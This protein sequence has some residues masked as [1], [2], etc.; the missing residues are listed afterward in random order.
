[1]AACTLAGIVL[2]PAGAVVGGS[3]PAAVASLPAL[4]AAGAA[5]GAA[6]AVALTCGRRHAVRVTGRVHRRAGPAL[7]AAAREAAVSATRW[8]VAAALAVGVLVSAA[9]GGGAASDAGG[10]GGGG[11]GVDAAT[12]TGVWL[13]LALAFFIASAARV[14]LGATVDWRALPLALPRGVDADDLLLAVL[15]AP[16]SPAYGT[17]PEWAAAR[18]GGAIGGGGAAAEAAAR[19][20]VADA[21]A[22]RALAG[23]AALAG[24]AADGGDA[25]RRLFAAPPSAGRWATAAG[26][27][28][29]PLVRVATV[30]A[31]TGAVGVGAGVKAG[32]A[33]EAVS[34]LLA[35]SVTED[36]FGVAGGDLPVVLGVLLQLRATLRG[37]GGGWRDAHHEA[38]AAVGAA[39]AA[40]ATAAATP[41]GRARRRHGRARRWAAWGWRL[42][43]GRPWGGDPAA[44]GSDPVE[45]LEA[46]VE[47]AVH[48]VVD[49]FRDHLEDVYL[50][51]GEPRWD[52]RADPELRAVLR[53]E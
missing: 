12:A 11:G 20:D 47:A 6:S 42:A 31:A 9:G 30:A 14:A 50:A 17:A 34:T 35:A 38:A 27:C 29:A 23:L 5:A 46:A 21:T 39:A 37:V 10:G 33:A 15:A 24:G 3:P 32:A 41:A 19:A 16:A 7:L 45:A 43:V 25:R 22:A 4:A 52:R 13:F 44:A 36:V 26:A 2:T 1:V 48:R 18:P 51:G 28:V 53:F 49:A 8:T 40:A